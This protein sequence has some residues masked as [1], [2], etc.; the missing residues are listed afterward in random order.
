MDVVEYGAIALFNERA[1]AVDHRFR[2]SD[3]NTPIVAEVCRRLDGI[4]LAIELAAARLNQLSLKALAQKLDDRFR[5]LAGGDRTALLR[6]QTMRATIDW[7]YDL[8]SPQEQRVFERLSVFAGGC[9]LAAA[10]AVCWGEETAEPD[11]FDLLSSLVDKSLL[12]ADFEGTEPRYRLLESS[13]AY[14]REKLVARGELEMVAQRH[15]RA[16]LEIT[17]QL[18]VAYD[19][20]ADAAWNERTQRE[21][22]NWRAVLE[23]ALAAG[24]DV[25]LGQ[26]LIGKLVGGMRAALTPSEKRHLIALAMNLVDESTPATVLASISYADA[27]VSNIFDESKK[28][29]AS[30]EKA[31]ALYRELGNDLGIAKSRTQAA[32]ALVR[33]GRNTEAE[34]MLLD[35]L[36]YFRQLG[37]RR[38]IGY[39][40]RV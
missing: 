24:R 5:I 7:S 1:L 38:R 9:T 29:L 30:S 18:E 21:L 4:P 26:R 13:R 25:A 19:S 27:V 14:A 40:L 33:L 35:A 22:D 31:L 10:T 17:E 28:E 12:V 6:Q 11:V 20:E 8:L 32:R 34:P 36:T 2:L 23:W 3:E 15:A 37:D 39:V 16:Y